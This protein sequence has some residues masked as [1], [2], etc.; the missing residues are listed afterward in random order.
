MHA[1]IHVVLTIKGYHSSF[2]VAQVLWGECVAGALYTEDFKRMARA[3]GFTDVRTLASS[4]VDVNHAQLRKLLGPA[5]FQS[6][7]LRL[8][9]LPG[10]LETACEDY[11]HV[12]TYKVCISRVHT[13]LYAQAIY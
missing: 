10:L 2:W 4:P 6:L 9:K 12:I 5:K 13:V 3:A 1:C 11:G 8:F 7:T